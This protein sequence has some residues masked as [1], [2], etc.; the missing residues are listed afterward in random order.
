MGVWIHRAQQ[1]P[2]VPLDAYLLG[3]W[4][5]NDAQPERYSPK[6]Q[7]A[8]ARRNTDDIVDV[9]RRLNERTKRES[10]RTA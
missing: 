7:E 3:S 1:F 6:L 2:I 8:R 9:A 5:M 4:M 10:S